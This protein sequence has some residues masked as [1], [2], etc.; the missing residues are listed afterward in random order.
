MYAQSLWLCPGFGKLRGCRVEAT[1]CNAGA[2]QCKL[3]SA[4][5]AIPSLNTKQ[6]LGAVHENEVNV[7]CE[8]TCRILVSVCG[9]FVHDVNR[10]CE[11][12][13]WVGL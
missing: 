13:E 11:Q 8:C 4:L 1:S 10:E 9:M 5:P 3:N 2:T 12:V 6:I 7:A